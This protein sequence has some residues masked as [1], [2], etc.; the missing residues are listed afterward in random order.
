MMEYDKEFGSVYIHYNNIWSKIE[1]LFSLEYDDIQSIMKVWLERDYNLR[2]LKLVNLNQTS[3]F[4]WK[5][6]TI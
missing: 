6:I 1:S 3:S 2:N 5:E 4:G